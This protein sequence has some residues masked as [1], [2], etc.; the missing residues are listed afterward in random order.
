MNDEMASIE[1]NQTCK[2]V[3]LPKEKKVV[4]LKWVY[5][6]KHNEDDNIQ[7]YKARLIAKGYSQQLGVDFTKIFALLL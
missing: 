6:T 1:N 2:L 7:K 3:E 5:Q 4:G